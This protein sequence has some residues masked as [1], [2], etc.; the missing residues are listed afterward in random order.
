MVL[1]HWGR[2]TCFAVL[3]FDW[4][5]GLRVT[6]PHQLMAHDFAVGVGF[7][8]RRCV[9]GVKVSAWGF[10]IRVMRC[11]G[12]AVEQSNTATLR[13]YLP[14]SLKHPKPET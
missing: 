5:L 7:D 2:K 12:S 6:R 1:V 8:F 9:R 11:C 14:E 13:P 10:G 3:H 4:G